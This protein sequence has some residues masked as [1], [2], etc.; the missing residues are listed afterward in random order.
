M[1]SLRITLGLAA[2]LTAGSAFAADSNAITVWVDAVRQP[3]AEAF[4]LGGIFED[5][6]FDKGHA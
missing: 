3:A 1:K 4:L 5:M 6:F 2:L